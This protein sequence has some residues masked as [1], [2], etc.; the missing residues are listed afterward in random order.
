MAKAL[1]QA[2]SRR[3]AQRVLCLDGLAVKDGDFIDIGKPIG[4]VFPVIVHTLLFGR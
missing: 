2:L 3:T 4:G 1:G